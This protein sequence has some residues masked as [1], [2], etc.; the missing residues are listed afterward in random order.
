MIALIFF[1]VVL[2]MIVMEIMSLRNTVEHLRVEYDIDMELAAPDEPL[3]L[4]YTVTNAGRRP[5]LFVSFALYFSSGAEI[6]EGEEFCNKYVSNDL[7][8]LS[9]NH[10]LFLL[11]HRKYQGRLHFSFKE[12]GIHKLGKFYLEAGDF[13]GFRNTLSTVE[14]E[15]AVVVTARLSEE[16]QVIDTLGGML[17]DISVRRF[18][19]EDPNLI[20]GYHDYTGRE[21]MRDISWLQTAKQGKLMVRQ[22]DFTVDNTVAVVVNQEDAPRA[23]SEECLRLTRTVCEILEERKI[24]YAFLSNGDLGEM[25]EGLGKSHLNRILRKIGVCRHACFGSF[26]EL[27]ERC[28]NERLNNRSYIVITPGVEDEEQVLLDLLRRY[29]DHELCVVTVRKE[30]AA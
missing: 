17:G 3:T 8:Q 23:V 16:E 12:R 18:I 22:N 20:I 11:P 5:L 14:A 25:S 19:F 29:S 7:S 9:V 24:P 15:K 30:A 1:G 26:R 4:R 2:V 6:R 27:I 28:I 21:P 10:H 13:L